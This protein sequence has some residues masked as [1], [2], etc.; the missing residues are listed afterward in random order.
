MGTLRRYHGNEQST[1][2]ESDRHSNGENWTPFLLPGR[3]VII[4]NTHHYVSQFY[5]SPH[6]H[7][8]FLIFVIAILRL[9]EHKGPILFTDLTRPDLGDFPFGPPNGKIAIAKIEKKVCDRVRKVKVRHVMVTL[10]CRPG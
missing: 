7:R 4:G 5:C 10:P 6:V 9:G 8:L 3:D 2:P 1:I